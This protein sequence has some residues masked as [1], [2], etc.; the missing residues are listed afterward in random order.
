[1]NNK[2]HHDHDEEK[3]QHE[4]EP[5]PPH[6]WTLNPE[7]SSVARKKCFQENETYFESFAKDKG[8][9]EKQWKALLDCTS[10][11]AHGYIERNGMKTVI[12]EDPKKKKH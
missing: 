4:H 9:C 8:L 2:G 1:M 11:H 12:L 3:G 5:H 6:G 10:F 7:A